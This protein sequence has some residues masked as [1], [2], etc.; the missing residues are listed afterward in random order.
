MAGN[1]R[2]YENQQ[3]GDAYDGSQRIQGK[4]TESGG[5]LILPY[6]AIDNI[7]KKTFDVGVSTNNQAS[8]QGGDEN[9][10]F[11]LSVT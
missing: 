11:Y 7:R 9:S 1:W 10:S 5:K 3:Y 6:S 8:I 2:P 4:V